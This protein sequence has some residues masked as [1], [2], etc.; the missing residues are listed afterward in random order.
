MT[1]RREWFHSYKTLATTFKIYMGNDGQQE[2]IGIEFVYIK[3][4]TS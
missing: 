4:N 3:I 1:P 2:A